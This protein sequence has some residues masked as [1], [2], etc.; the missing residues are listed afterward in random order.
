MNTLYVNYTRTGKAIPDHLVEKELFDQAGIC[1]NGQDN[2]FNISTENVISAVRSMKLAGRIICNVQLM[3][4]GEILP[5]NEYGNLDKWPKG[6]CDYSDNWTAEIIKHQ[7]K[8]YK[9]VQ[10]Y[11]KLGFNVD[12]N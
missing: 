2:L 9:G 1:I 12:Q 7:L 10:S 5:M 3:F 8:R 4:E 6:F 11:G